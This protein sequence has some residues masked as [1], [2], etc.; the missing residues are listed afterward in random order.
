VVPESGETILARTLRVIHEAGIEPVLVGEAAWLDE[1]AQ[2]VRR[3]AD[4]APG[5]G[6]LA[7]LAALLDEAEDRGVDRVIAIACDMPYVTAALLARLVEADTTRAIV[8]PRGE[9]EPARW[10]ALFARYERDRVSPVVHELLAARRL[11]LQAVF[12]RVEAE[13]LEVSGAERD[14][15][16]DWDEPHDVERGRHGQ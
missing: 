10:D 8:A 15:L 2:R 12:D 14:L 4:R 9:R 16:R 11:S 13:P 3:I 7:G 6:P 1:A 5:A